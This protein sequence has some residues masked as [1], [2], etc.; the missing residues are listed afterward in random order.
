MWRSKLL[1]MLYKQYQGDP[2]VQ[3]LYQAAG[4]KLDDVELGIAD[5]HDQRFFDTA[6]WG[7]AIYERAL[8]ITPR[9]GQTLEERR[10]IVSAKW[11][12]GGKV[13]LVLLQVIVD[14]W[15]NGEVEVGF[16]N[17]KITLV[18]CGAYGVPEDMDS[19]MDAIGQ[20]KPAHLPVV[21][22]IRYLLIRDIHEV[23]P[24][25]EMERTPLKYFAAGRY[26]V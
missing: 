3:A 17:G 6:T 4:G 18:F 2:W 10:S 14:A 24:V 16:Q 1:E 7:L 15:K 12:T 26:D 22:Q 5:L 23:M 21:Y 19:L 11:R 20:A 13:D 9:A 25:A 8:G